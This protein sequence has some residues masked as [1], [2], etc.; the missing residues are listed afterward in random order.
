MDA[1]GLAVVLDV[2]HRA[3]YDTFSHKMDLLKF[4][5]HLDWLN[6]ESF[7]AFTPVYAPAGD[8]CG[9]FENRDC[10]NLTETDIIRSSKNQREVQYA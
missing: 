6:S 10:T 3:G 1:N 8:V 5:N 7:L 4:N 2:G 9:D